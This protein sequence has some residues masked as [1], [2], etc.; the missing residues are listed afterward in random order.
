ME[1]HVSLATPNYWNKKGDLMVP[2]TVALDGPSSS[3]GTPQ[4]KPY[5]H[6]N[7]LGYTGV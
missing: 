5:T 4:H 7:Q 6:N 3:E 2:A 1:E